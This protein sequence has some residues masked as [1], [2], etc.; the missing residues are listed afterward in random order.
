MLEK[1]CS[2]V[3]LTLVVHTRLPAAQ[4]TRLSA[5]SNTHTTV[6]SFKHTGQSPKIWHWWCIPV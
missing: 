1:S 2:I 4:F 5:H 6:S 3:D